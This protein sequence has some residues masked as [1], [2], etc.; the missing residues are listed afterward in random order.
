M[1]GNLEFI[2]CSSDRIT[3]AYLAE[4]SPSNPSRVAR[5]Y[6]RRSDI[7]AKMVGEA[8]LVWECARVEL[9]TTDYSIINQAST[10]TSC[11]WSTN[12][13]EVSEWVSGHHY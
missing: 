7:A 6:L 4:A 1:V 13:V 12:G 8:I 5:T 10:M 9:H 3:H 2:R 11:L